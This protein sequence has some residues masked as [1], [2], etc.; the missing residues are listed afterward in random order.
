MLPTKLRVCVYASIFGGDRN[1]SYFFSLCLLRE[2]LLQTSFKF[3][4]T[5]LYNYLFRV[6]FIILVCSSIEGVCIFLRQCKKITGFF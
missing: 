3:F 1:S 6:L 2:E 5:K 4:S